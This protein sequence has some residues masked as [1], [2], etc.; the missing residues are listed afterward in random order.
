MDPLAVL[1]TIWHHKFAALPV[2]FVTLIAAVYVFQFAP[3]SY[4]STMTYAVINPSIPTD[5]DKIANP[6][7]KKLNSSNPYLRASDPTLVVQVL[8]TRLKDT[9][10]AD[11][12]ASKGLSKQY[13]VVRGA[14]GGQ[15]SFLVDITGDASTPAQS[16][17]TTKRL[18]E[19]LTEDLSSIQKIDG[20]DDAYLFTSLVV[21][22]PDKAT[23]QFS[24]RLRSLIGVLVGGLVLMFGAVSIARGRAK[25]RQRREEAARDADAA[26]ATGSQADKSAEAA[27]AAEEPSPQAP[28]S[29]VDQWLGPDLDTLTEGTG[30]RR[31][32]RRQD[33]RRQEAEAHE[34]VREVEPSR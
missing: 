24:S 18:G 20:A 23:E 28:A 3:R 26:A 33:S 16:I 11:D 34:E 1:K 10:T 17:A 29:D 14:I 30:R 21:A 31:D 22:T 2:V 19:L 12:L 8:I 25:A 32:S 15:N 13:D 5:A 6:A 7:L 9:S 4:E 27:P